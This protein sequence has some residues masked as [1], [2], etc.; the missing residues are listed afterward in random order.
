MTEQ[1]F[2]SPPGRDPGQSVASFL[3]GFAAWLAGDARPAIA[4]QADRLRAVPAG[5]R[6]GE[7]L[8]LVL[9]HLET[10]VLELDA[11]ARAIAAEPRTSDGLGLEP[12]LSAAADRCGETR[13]LMSRARRL[14]DGP[15]RPAAAPE[16][17]G[18]RPE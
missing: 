13:E 14:L 15:G 1:P 6:G 9:R 8:A 5:P 2:P 11:L 4:A 3:E 12:L 10:L 16:G 7:E 18:S 17:C